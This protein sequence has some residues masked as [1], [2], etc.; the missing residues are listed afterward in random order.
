VYGYKI[1]K[2]LL[3]VSVPWETDWGIIKEEKVRQLMC[4]DIL[5]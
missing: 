2:D 1:I 5:G 4:V 3:T